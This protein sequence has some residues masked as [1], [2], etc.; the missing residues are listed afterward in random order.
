[1]ETN[2]VWEG[3]KFMVLGMSVVFGFL[4]FLVIVQAPQSGGGADRGEEGKRVAAIM[5]AVSA[6]R[7]N[8]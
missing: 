5:A 1:M 6:F 8:K 2:L 7:K 3:T 4:I